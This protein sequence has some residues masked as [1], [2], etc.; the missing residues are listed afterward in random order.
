M[1]AGQQYQYLE[2]GGD[3]PVANKKITLGQVVTNVTGQDITSCVC[4]CV[5]VCVC[6]CVLQHHSRIHHTSPETMHL[7]VFLY[8]C[9]FLYVLSYIAAH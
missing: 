2:R 6:V 5:R 8:V 1:W 3:N 7:Y 4:V 9:F